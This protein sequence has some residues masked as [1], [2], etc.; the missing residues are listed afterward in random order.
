M[1]IRDTAFR[2][3]KSDSGNTEL[4]AELLES[5]N[6][7]LISHHVA[8][9]SIFSDFVQGSDWPALAYLAYPG[10][11][12]SNMS[13]QH[14]ELIQGAQLFLAGGHASSESI[15]FWDAGYLTHG[16]TGTIVRWQSSWV[17]FL[18]LLAAARAGG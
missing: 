9:A 4:H 17:F 3:F 16:L 14:A 18:R 11:T 13:Q 7:H 5:T 12:Q 6:T 8:S 10:K 2:I 15:L 1:S